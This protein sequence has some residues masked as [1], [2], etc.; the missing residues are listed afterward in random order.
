VKA[1]R[2]YTMKR[3]A[4]RLDET[5]QR[6]VDATAAL[7]EEVGPARTTVTAIA[8]RAGV[9]RPT[10]YNQFPDDRSLFAA[11]SGHF[12]EQHPMPELE[13]EE[14]EGTLAG[15]YAYFAENRRMLTNIDRDAR[16]LPAVA[17][18]YGHA[19]AV[20]ARAADWHAERIAPGDERVRAAA[21]LAFSFSTWQ[22]LDDAGLDAN[23]AATLLASLARA[24]AAS[25]S[26]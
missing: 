8:Q 15:L 13:D 19:L 3:R 10:V 22:T 20:R 25:V 5:R 26:A 1:K 14:L 18:V 16:L 21:R 6:I 17:D 2:S 24:A 11:C 23:E 9:S 12:R 7:H 4:E